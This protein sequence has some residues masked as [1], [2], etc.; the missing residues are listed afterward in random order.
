MIIDGTFDAPLEVKS[1]DDAGVFEG[2]GAVFG[3]VDA[4]GDKLMPGAFAESLAKHRR[5]GTRVAMLWQHDQNALPLGVWDD[6]AEDGKG[7]WGKGRLNL[8]TVNGREAHS[9]MKMGSLA[10]LSIGYQTVEDKMEGAVRH[11]KRV[12]LWEVSLVNFPMNS[13]AVVNQVKA[14]RLG[15]ALRDFAQRFR[16]GEPPAIKEFEA[17]LRDAGLPKSKAVEIA[18]H[19]Y[20]HAVRGDPEGTEANIAAEFLRALRG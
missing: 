14:D 17:L 11:L 18:S 20:A 12:Q 1:L 8:E 7:L 4:G 6:M 10:G 3:N 16:E 2:Y 15:A 9:A 19:G 5:E 13:R